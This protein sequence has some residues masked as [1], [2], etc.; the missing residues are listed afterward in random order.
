MSKGF[1]RVVL[2]ISLILILFI[3][4]YAFS[5]QKYNHNKESYNNNDPQ[6]V[7]NFNKLENKGND[8]KVSENAKIVF[9]AEYEKS[10]EIKVIEELDQPGIMVGLNK[11]DIEQIYSKEGYIVESITSSEVVL[12]KKINSY[13]PNKYFLGI[14]NNQCVAIFKTDDKGKE[15]IENYDS[16][17]K[18]DV[19]I[20]RLK[21]GDKDILTN[22]SPDLQF[23]TK[24]DAE[25]AFTEAYR[26]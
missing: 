4:S 3:L 19:K 1:L 10:R 22:G 26:T 14:Y 13:S 2:G 24:N 8:A 18:T 23:E 12:L 6:S 5:F 7:A 9:Q 20:E 11:S 25:A 21:K 15:F 17:V 16:D